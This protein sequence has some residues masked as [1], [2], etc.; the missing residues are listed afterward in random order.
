MFQKSV[1]LFFYCAAAAVA[2]LSLLCFPFSIFFLRR[3]GEPIYSLNVLDSIHGTKYPRQSL[4]EY[5]VIRLEESLCV[6]ESPLDISVY[7]I[8]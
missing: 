6:E 1:C 7:V 8:L 5:N 3:G 2:M 4:E